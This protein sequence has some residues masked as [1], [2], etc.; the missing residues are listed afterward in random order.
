MQ[1]TSTMCQKPNTIH[2]S[3]NCQES[4]KAPKRIVHDERILGSLQAD[5]IYFNV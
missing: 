4:H 1:P 5:V 2:T 3:V